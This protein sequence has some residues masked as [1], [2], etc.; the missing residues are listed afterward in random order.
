MAFGPKSKSAFLMAWRS[1]ITP[2]V[3]GFPANLFVAILITLL[4]CG[5]ITPEKKRPRKWAILIALLIWCLCDGWC[6]VT[7]NLFQ[8]LKKEG[9]PREVKSYY[10]VYSIMV[11]IMI[12]IMIMLYLIGRCEMDKG[13][14]CPDDFCCCSIWQNQFQ[15]IIK[16]SILKRYLSI[17]FYQIIKNFAVFYHLFKYNL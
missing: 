2:V 8:N 12:S 15:S 7:E 13:N 1:L 5:F 16:S 9:F 10:L 4:I 11:R 17:A 14:E 3:D 6:S